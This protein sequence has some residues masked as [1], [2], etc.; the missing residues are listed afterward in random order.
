MNEHTKDETMNSEVLSEEN[1]TAETV[2]EQKSETSEQSRVNSPFPTEDVND[3]VYARYRKRTHKDK[4]RHHHESSSDDYTK[5]TENQNTQL[6]LSDS[7]THFRDKLPLGSKKRK[8]KK[9]P[10][11]KKLLVILAW[12]LGIIMILSIIATAAVFILRGVGIKKLTGYGDVNMTAPTIENAGIYLN[13]DGKTVM[14]KGQEYR[15]NE[16]MTSIMCIGVDRDELGVDEYLGTGGQGDALFLI[17][18][19]TTT[20]ETTVIAVPRDIVTDIGIYSSRGEYMKTEKHQLCL[21]YAYGDGKKTS[22]MNTVTAVSRLFYNMPINS[23]FSIDLSSIA[24][25]NDAVGGV[26]VKMI[27]DSFY[28]IYNVHHFAGEVITLRGDN[29]RKYVQQRDVYELE[30]STDRINRQ[31]NY[32]NAFTSKTL[33]KTKKDIKTPLNLLEIV[34]SNSVTNLDASTIT[35]FATCLVTNGVSDLEFSKVPG[36]LESDGTYAQYIVDEE[37]LY[38]LILDIYYSPVN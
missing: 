24:T 26:T 13:D 17:A 16:D 30:S 6:V 4:H 11:W 28:D 31:I 38:E 33:S 9:Q 23:Y 21:A 1:T 12:L 36:H 32:L 7:S 29:A 22:C 35:A 5:T 27:D 8:W 18:L 2:A 15:F 14:Y 20:G 25:L 10:W 3:Y 37:K 34:E 19:D